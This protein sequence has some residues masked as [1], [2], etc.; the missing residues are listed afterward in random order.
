MI[1][2]ATGVLAATR[3][4]RRLFQCARLRSAGGLRLSG[5]LSPAT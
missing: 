2:N 4:S 3:A 5:G 1:Q